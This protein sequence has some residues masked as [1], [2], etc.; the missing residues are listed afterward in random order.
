MLFL[1]LLN[2]LKFYDNKM[3]LMVTTALAS[4]SN[5]SLSL[6][7]LMVNWIQKS[8]E[9]FYICP[10]TQTTIFCFVFPSVKVTQLWS[11]PHCLCLC[12][13]FCLCLCLCLISNFVSTW[14]LPSRPA[15]L[16]RSPATHSLAA[17][18]PPPLELNILNRIFKFKCEYF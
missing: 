12:L 18:S 11:Q 13:C 7:S 16:S 3:R 8:S 14:L 4:S 10:K 17:S 15:G 1:K 6:M 9:L 5:F 2:V